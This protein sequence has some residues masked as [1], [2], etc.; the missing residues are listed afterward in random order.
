[1]A[2][3]SHALSLAQLACLLPANK[4]RTDRGICVTLHTSRCIRQARTG[5]AVAFTHSHPLERTRSLAQVIRHANCIHSLT[6]TRAHAFAR[7]ANQ[8]RH[9]HSLTHTHS[10]AFTHSH[11]L[12][13][14]RSLSYSGTPPAYIQH[15]AMRLQMQR[16]AK[17]II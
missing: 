1:M 6:P 17:L 9:L 7:S 10:S 5:T 4:L 11:P 13:R 16:D 2:H 14:M 15:A 3:G 12:E 8:A